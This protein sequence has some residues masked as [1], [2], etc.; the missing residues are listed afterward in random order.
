MHRALLS[1]LVSARLRVVKSALGSTTLSLTLVMSALLGSGCATPARQRAETPVARNNKAVLI[2]SLLSDGIERA[3]A[4]SG[5]VSG[6]K[7]D[8]IR[9]CV[10]LGRLDATLADLVRTVARPGDSEQ[11]ERN[12]VT[13][14]LF[15][16]RDR[17]NAMV[18]FCGEN[19]G[20]P[21]AANPTLSRL[22][23]WDARGL[24]AEASQVVSELEAFKKK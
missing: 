3:K 13:A 23:K 7:P 1:A 12:D 10:E 22:R 11:S 5:A 15:Q 16:A 17:A 19:S 8:G 14:P 4:A 9:A 2:S 21:L 20:A 18:G 24:R 6:Q